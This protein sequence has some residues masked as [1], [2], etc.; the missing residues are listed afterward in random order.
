MGLSRRFEHLV[1]VGGSGAGDGDFL[2]D[3]NGGCDVFEEF[4]PWFGQCRSSGDVVEGSVCGFA[5]SGE[6]WATAANAASAACSGATADGGEGWT[7][8]GAKAAIDATT[9]GGEGRTTGGATA[10]ID[11]TAD[12]G[13]GRTTACEASGL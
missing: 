7:T 10:A 1:G 13:E 2:E 4:N 6:G 11:A 12:G 5:C 8:G 3:S 9:D